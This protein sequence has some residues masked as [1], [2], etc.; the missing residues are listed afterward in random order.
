MDSLTE[1]YI[2]ISLPSEWTNAMQLFKRKWTDLQSTAI[3][4]GILMGILGP[5][6]CSQ[7]HCQEGAT[8]NNGNHCL[9]HCLLNWAGW[10]GIRSHGQYK[11]RQM[12]LVGLN[13]NLEMPP[14]HTKGVSEFVHAQADP[15]RQWQETTFKLA[16]KSDYLILWISP[17]NSQKDGRTGGPGTG[18]PGSDVGLE[19]AR[20]R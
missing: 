19:T 15:T 4:L 1:K 10:V 5:A 14:K 17:D 7:Y 13:G 20:V 12:F 8:C 18:F 16:L 11:E 2:L 3:W 6:D 9:S